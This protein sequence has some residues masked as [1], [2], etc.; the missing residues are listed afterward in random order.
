M[1]DT[2]QAD[3]SNTTEQNAVDIGKLL[4]EHKG[5]DVLV[6]DMRKINFW[7]DF[8]VIGTVS[9][10]IHLSGLERHIKDFTRE[11]GIDILTHSAKP[12][13]GEE[14]SLID[15][16][17]IVVHLMTPRARSFYE[18]ERLWSAA[19]IIYPGAAGKTPV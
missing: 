1:D 17:A 14:W 2:L 4:C 9:S 8:F 11:R 5:G 3:R 12:G 16:G 13:A 10:S 19:S 6:M 7:T 18:L 15:L